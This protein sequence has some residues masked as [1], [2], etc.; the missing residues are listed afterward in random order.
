MTPYDTYRFYQIERPKSRSEIRRA[1]EQ[2]GCL[3]AA[4]SRLAHPLT[5]F[6]RAPQPRHPAAIKDVA[7]RLPQQ[8]ARLQE[9]RL[10]ARA[11]RG[12]RLRARALRGGRLRA[13]ALPEDCRGTVTG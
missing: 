1:D 2:A 5:W 8:A 6:A 11:L 13:P 3:A 9:A 7:P 10:R 12:G 4:V